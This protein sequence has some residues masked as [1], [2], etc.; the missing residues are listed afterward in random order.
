VATA[1]SGRDVGRLLAE[2]DASMYDVKGRI[3]RR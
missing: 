2:A 3:R 1:G